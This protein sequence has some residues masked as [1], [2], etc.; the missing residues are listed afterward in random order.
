MDKNERL[1][2]ALWMVSLLGELEISAKMLNDSLV[3][4]I[5]MALLLSPDTEKKTCE[6]LSFLEK[7]IQPVEKL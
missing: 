3:D 2:K 4:I 6:Q 1:L 5:H 7:V